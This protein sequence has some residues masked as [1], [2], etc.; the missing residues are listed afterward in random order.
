M[1]VL[2]LFAILLFAEYFN[3]RMHL[4][5]NLSLLHQTSL[6]PTVHLV[7][8]RIHHESS[9]VDLVKG[10]AVYL[11]VAIESGRDTGNA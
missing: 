2:G 6:S 10:I 9:C 11:V 3:I 8:R 1:I 4:L 7:W 5:F